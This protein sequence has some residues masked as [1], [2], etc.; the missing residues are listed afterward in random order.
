M[1]DGITQ[2]GPVKSLHDGYGFRVPGF[3]VHPSCLT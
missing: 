2:Y 1:I 3:V